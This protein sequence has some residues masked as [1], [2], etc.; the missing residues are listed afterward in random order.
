MIRRTLR[1]FPVLVVL[2]ASCA[3]STSE[4]DV[5]LTDAVIETTVLAD[6]LT[7]PWELLWGPDGK[8]WMSEKIGKISKVDTSTGE[9]Q[10]IYDIPDVKVA[11]EGGLLGVAL[12][13]D[14]QSTPQVFVVYD[15]DNGGVYTEKV[16]RFTYLNKTLTS[17]VTLIDNI[18]ANGNHN[19]SRLLFTPDK[20]LLITT[21][22]AGVPTDA[23]DV[24]KLNGKILRINPDGSIPPGNP[25][26]ASPV[27]TLGHRNPQGLT[28]VA[29]KL[30]SSEHG[31]SNDDEINIIAEGRN[32]GW[33]NVQGFCD[34]EA[35]KS[36]C[37]E[38]NVKEPIYAWT[39]TLA[40]CGI[41]YYDK[42]EI[43]QW[44]NSL[45]MCTLKDQTFYQ[46]KLSEDHN[47]IDSVKK[48][49]TGVYGRL[50]DVCISPDGKVF[51]ATSNGSNDK[52]IKL[53]RSN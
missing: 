21:G 8:I 49:F 29:D 51:V 11:G 9:T 45:L 20:K 28:Y 31:P 14:F 4:P 17:P 30:F 38:K 33:P 36:Y 6:Q 15:Y 35:E 1:Y 12:H 19:G 50:R 5:P 42:K 25:D 34:A 18:R 52:I 7:L 10:L 24:A 3:K 32:Y 13:P 37:G 53:Q 44:N 26:P 46:L 48:I 23:Q 39:P 43:S 47:S 22:D 27:W 16:V 41:E 2:L 40:V